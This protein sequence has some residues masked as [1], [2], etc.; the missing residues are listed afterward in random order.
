MNETPLTAEGLFDAMRA[1]LD[2]RW[3][4]GKR[5]GKQ[6]L[7][8]RELPLSAR[9]PSLVG[10]LNFIHSN[11]VQIVGLEE[12]AYLDNLDSRQRWDLLAKLFAKKPLAIIVSNKNAMPADI[13]EGAEEAGTPLWLSSKRGH[14]ILNYL[15]HFLTRAIARTTT[16]HGVFLEVYSLGVL[17]TGES[18]AGKSELALELISRGH[19]LVADDAP[20]FTLVEPEVL[21]GGCPAILQDVL[22]VRGLGILNIREMF[23][24]TAVKRNKYLRLIIHLMP[25]AMLPEDQIDRLYGS[26]STRRILDVEIPVITLPVAPGRN[27]AVLLEAAVRNHALKLKGVDAT[28]R[29]IERQKKLISQDSIW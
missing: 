14:E 27:L 22:E 18:G 12:L 25:L 19:R 29:F 15:Q 9:K 21:D 2:L 16:V 7:E 13:K 4:A 28:Q 26:Y 20:E 5:G 3:E 1:R 11:R 23:G 10:Y 17:V 6:L 24:D 8:P